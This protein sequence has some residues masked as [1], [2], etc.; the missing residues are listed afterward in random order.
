M[1]VCEHVWMCKCAD[2]CAC[3]NVNKCSVFEGK[4]VIHTDSSHVFST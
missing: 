4:E 1:H 2:V 3:E